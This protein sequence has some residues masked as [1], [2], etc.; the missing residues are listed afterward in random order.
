MKVSDVL[1]DGSKWTKGRY[2]E[3]VN[4][5]NCGSRSPNAIRWCL[6]GALLKA[7]GENVDIE[8][9]SRYEALRS[10]VGNIKNSKYYGTLSTFNDD[11][12]TTFEDIKKVLELA[13]E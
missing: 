5:E 11:T 13:G 12:K 3:D 1:T 4:G 7:C 2:G 9:S 10:A 6:A 8:F